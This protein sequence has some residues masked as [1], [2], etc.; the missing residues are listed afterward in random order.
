MDWTIEKTTSSD[1][2]EEILELRKIVYYKE[3]PEKEEPLYWDWEYLHNH[4]G[5]AEKFVV[6]NVK[7]ELIGYYAFVPQEYTIRGKTYTAGLPVDAM[8]DP[9]YR[10]KG[11][12]SKL[13]EFAIKNT[14]LDFLIGYTIRKEVLPAE[15][16]GGYVI[17]KKIPVYI[18]PLQFDVL[19]A[20]YVP[21]KLLAK[22]LGYFPHFFYK[23]IFKADKSNSRYKIKK[24]EN[25]TD[26]LD[27]FFDRRVVNHKVYLNKD[28]EYLSWRFDKIPFVEYEKY[29]VLNEDNQVVAYYV[30]REKKVLG[31]NFTN[32]VDLELVSEEKDL[33]DTV[34]NDVKIRAGEKDTAG[35][36]YQ[37][38][39]NTFISKS[40]K[41]MGFLTAPNKINLIMQDTLANDATKQFIN[42]KKVWLNWSDTDL[43]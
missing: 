41:K 35:V 16:K 30:I 34:L 13:Q 20:E 21:S 5:E 22:I 3:D 38:L 6:L 33:L 26:S 25:I 31:V 15:L 12:F 32:I 1:R 37:L 9:N 42:A 39:D 11:I 23:L 27:D 18:F 8:I 19:A 7:N 17:A 4:Y 10:R 24:V 40:L 28:K 43:M 14:A 29:I 2:R 36:A